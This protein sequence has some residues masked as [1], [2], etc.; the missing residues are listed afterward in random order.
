MKYVCGSQAEEKEEGGTNTNRNP[1]TR[2]L[3][4][5]IAG[6]LVKKRFFSKND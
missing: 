3:A 1:L 4:M 6:Q 5:L 2:N